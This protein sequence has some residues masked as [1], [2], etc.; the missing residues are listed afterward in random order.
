VRVDS[1]G[2]SDGLM[3]LAS[4]ATAAR[5][6]AGAAPLQLPSGSALEL[7]GVSYH[8]TSALLPS[9]SGTMAGSA[10]PAPGTHA[11]CTGLLGGMLP[12]LGKDANEICPWM[13]GAVVATKAAAYPPSN[14]T[15]HGS[16]GARSKHTD[17]RKPTGPTASM[18]SPETNAPSG[19][20]PFRL[21]IDAFCTCPTAC[22]EFVAPVGCEHADTS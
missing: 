3:V 17:W 1:I 13:Q 19:V 9:D 10:A 20:V 7:A 18:H 11:A 22:T 5:S 15:T 6:G 14:G 2:L 8:A 12:A 16:T 4:L 21:T